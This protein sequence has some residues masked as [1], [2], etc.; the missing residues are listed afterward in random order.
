MGKK[1]RI[2][3][4]FW[5]II[6]V[7]ILKE[8]WILPFGTFSRPRQGFFPFIIGIAL[9]FLSLIFFVKSWLGEKRTGEGLRFFFKEEEWKRVGLTVGTLFVF[10]FMFE[11][12]GFF[13]ATLFFVLI[14]IRFVEP[15]K[16]I[17]AA[18]VAVLISFCS[19]LL[20][21]VILKSNLPMGILGGLGF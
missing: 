19:Y 18:G 13:L 6:S 1:D 9:G 16:W 12:A 4:I 14:L 17:Y 7:L 21:Q 10:Y 5:L 3:S 20:F 8:S 2:S 15:H 11:S